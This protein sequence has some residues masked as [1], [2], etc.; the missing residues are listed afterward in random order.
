MTSLV[1]PVCCARAFPSIYGESI[2]DTCEPHWDP[3]PALPS[4]PTSFNSGKKIDGEPLEIQRTNKA[5]KY[6]AMVCIAPTLSA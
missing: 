1:E 5:R 3:L 6:C 4:V 2:G